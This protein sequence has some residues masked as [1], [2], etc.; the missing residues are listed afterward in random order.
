LET[1]IE[2]FKE[3]GLKV[4]SQRIAVYQALLAHHGHP[5]AEAIYDAIKGNIPGLSLGTVYKTLDTFIESG[6]VQRVATGDDVLRFDAK[7]HPHHHIMVEGS[8][9]IIDF[10]DDEL[11]QM[12]SRYI[13]SKKFKG[14]EIQHFQIQLFATKTQES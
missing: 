9:E 8:N 5:T 10:E 14:L 12:L 7:I 13:Q 6:L 3:K 4:T 11:Q 1:I 2:K